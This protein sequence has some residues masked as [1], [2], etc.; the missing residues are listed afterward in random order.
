M[1][2]EAVDWGKGSVGV[3]KTG[4]FEASGAQIDSVIVHR[5]QA[6][7]YGWTAFYL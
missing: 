2:N 6:R 4:V 5:G 1:R 7:S 3:A